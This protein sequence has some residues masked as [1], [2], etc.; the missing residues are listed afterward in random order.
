MAPLAGLLLVAMTILLAV[1]VTAATTLGPPADPAPTATISMDVEGDRVTLS[2]DGGD[3]I[4]VDELSVRV[5]VNGEPL[6]RQPPVPFFS[7]AGF[8]PGPTGAFNAANEGEWVVGGSASFRVAGTNDPSIEP[9]D[10]VE[11][12]L[13]V[14]EQ[15][16]ATLEATAR[17]G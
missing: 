4:A 15:P 7:A 11:L 8:R 12:R 16:I 1:G 3:P 10:R 14:R 17:P 13:V 9:G 6:A 5:S 2:H